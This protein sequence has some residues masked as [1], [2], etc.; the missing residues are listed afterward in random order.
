[1]P[2]LIGAHMPT[3]EGGVPNAIRTGKEIGCEAIQVFTTSPR[4]W[5]SK[6]PDPGTIAETKRAMKDTGIDSVVSHD[7]YLVNLCAPDPKT[8][9]LSIIT[10]TNELNRC[11][12][13]GIPYVV[14]HMGA[15][16]GQEERD[17]MI[18]L[19]GSVARVLQET[20]PE[21]SIAMETTAGQGS[22]LG[23][24]FEHW[25]MIIE[26]H[27]GDPRLVICMDTCHLFAAGYPIHGREGYEKTMEEFGRLIGFA[28]LRVIHSN[29]SKKP[30][31]SRLDRHEHIGD[32]LLGLEPF[33]W[34]VNDPRLAHA[35]MIIETPDA[36]TMH[37]VNIDRLKSL[38]EN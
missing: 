16:K 35:P 21:V 15:L 7:T 29:D 3:G 23:Y 1:M 24:K 18:I 20:P 28:R 26:A 6:S 11:G 14:S 31:A 17:A 37:A 10:L 27:G 22:C 34:F 2:R 9:E 8:R 30:F 36:D 38:R 13:L 33:R 4:N 19:A 32:G 25:A 5:A 12:Q